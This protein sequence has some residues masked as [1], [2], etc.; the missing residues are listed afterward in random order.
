MS[1][2][3]L[4][5]EPETRRKRLRLSAENFA[6]ETGKFSAWQVRNIE[7]C[8]GRARVADLALVEETL[9]RLEH[10]AETPRHADAGLMDESLLL[11]EAVAVVER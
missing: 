6:R 9:T 7:R 5:S 4:A 1:T 3:R 2:K 11:R 10:E 8:P